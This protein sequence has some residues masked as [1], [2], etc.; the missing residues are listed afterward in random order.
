MCLHIFG[1]VYGIGSGWGKTC[2]IFTRVP[3][4][5]FAGKCIRET[6]VSSKSKFSS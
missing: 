3:R 4:F 6:P 2:R 1:D 5:L